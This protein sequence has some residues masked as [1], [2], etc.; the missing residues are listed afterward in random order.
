MRNL[1]FDTWWPLAQHLFIHLN[2]DCS[3][4]NINFDLWINFPIRSPKAPLQLSNNKSLYIF[5]EKKKDN[6]FIFSIS[7][8]KVLYNCFYG[9]FMNKFTKKLLDKKWRN[10]IGA[11]EAGEEEGNISIYF[12]IYLF[13]YWY[14]ASLFFLLHLFLISLLGYLGIFVSYEVNEMKRM[15]KYITSLYRL[16]HFLSSTWILMLKIGSASDA[17]FF[18]ICSLILGERKNNLLLKYAQGWDFFF[19]E[20]NKFLKFNSQYKWYARHAYYFVFKFKFWGLL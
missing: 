1:Q 10:F 19:F 16:H 8:S 18:T 12:G 11:R 4:I 17:L 5:Y 9:F 3:F 20:K 14:F 6:E 15:G 13:I 7:R 2:F